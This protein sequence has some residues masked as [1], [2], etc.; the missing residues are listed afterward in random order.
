M[1]SISG[2]T[3]ASNVFSVGKKIYFIPSSLASI[4]AG[5]AHP[6]GRTAPSSANS[7]KNKE[8]VTISF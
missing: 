8:D 3:D 6:T 4:V 2:I 5:N 1:I 7:H